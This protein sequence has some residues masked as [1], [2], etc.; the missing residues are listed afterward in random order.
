MMG[1]LA[2]AAQPGELVES[3]TRLA[4]K[5]KSRNILVKPTGGSMSAGSPVTQ[6]RVG[7]IEQEE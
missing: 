1:F 2:P 6:G 3:Y 4:F 7:G 5:L